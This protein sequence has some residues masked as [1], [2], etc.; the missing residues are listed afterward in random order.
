[1]AFP[2]ILATIIPTIL[3]GLINPQTVAATVN[4]VADKLGVS[5]RTKE[6]IE[7]ALSG[8]DAEGLIKLKSLDYEFQKF[9]MENEIKIDLAQIA[10][11]TE[12]AKHESLFVAG[13]RPAVG[14]ICASGLA[15]ACIVLPIMEFTARVGFGYQGKF[16]NIDWAI[17]SNVLL[18]ILG[19]GA[20]RSYDKR[21]GN[22]NERG[23]H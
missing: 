13:W 1:M 7:Q 20:M 12:E 14:W 21:H 17:L 23:K 15:Y 18:G 9:C 22:G 6:G 3:S 4:F 19:L 11:N 5:D 8:L 10:V 2:A 16:P